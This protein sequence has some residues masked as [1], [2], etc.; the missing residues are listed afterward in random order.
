[1]P[2]ERN[3][4]GVSDDTQHPFDDLESTRVINSNIKKIIEFTL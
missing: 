1:M 2:I 4:N 3:V